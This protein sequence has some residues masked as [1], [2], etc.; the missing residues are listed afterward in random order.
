MVSN[1]PCPLD[2]SLTNSI[3]QRRTIVQ[4]FVGEATLAQHHGIQIRTKKL[5]RNERK[6]VR[7]CQ[8]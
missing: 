1:H 8:L 5:V 6:V 2:H 4:L 3:E 7:R